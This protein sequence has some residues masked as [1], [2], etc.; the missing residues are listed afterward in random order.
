MAAGT[1][2]VTS[3]V[4]SLP[5]VAGDAALYVDPE[6][7]GSIAEGLRRILDDEE[8]RSRL[9]A[10]GSERIEAFSWA[11]CARQTADVLNRAAAH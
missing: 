5:E 6:D 10:A 2:V 8:L 11:A 3:N 9:R 7:E 4:S 1:P